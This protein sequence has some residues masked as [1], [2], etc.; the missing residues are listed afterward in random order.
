MSRKKSEHSSKYVSNLGEYMDCV[1]PRCG[2]VHGANI[3][4]TG[5]GIPRKYCDTCKAYIEKRP[6]ADLEDHAIYIDGES[7][8]STSIGV[9][10]IDITARNGENTKDKKG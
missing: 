3:Y 8:I 2:I 9:E 1:C 5:N 10:D 7:R 6:D 4:W